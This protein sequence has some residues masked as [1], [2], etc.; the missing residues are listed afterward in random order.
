M[1]IR[2]LKETTT[3]DRCEYLQIEDKK[4]GKAIFSTVDDSG[5]SMGKLCKY[6]F[7]DFM[8][9]EIAFLKRTIEKLNYR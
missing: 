9:A 1:K 4:S 8:N 3:C 5:H 6:C 2:P 7:S